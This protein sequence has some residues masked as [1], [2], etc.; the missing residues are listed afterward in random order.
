M[1]LSY[2]I[3]L[4]L[5]ILIGGLMS[6]SPAE[7]NKT[8]HE[9]MTDMAHSIAF[10]P[11]VNTYYSYNIWGTKQEHREFSVPRLPVA[12][13][14]ARGYSGT[15]SLLQTND[16]SISTTKNGHVNYY[17]KD[18]EEE[19]IRAANEIVSNPFPLTAKSLENGKAN[20]TIYCATCHGDKGD[21]GGYLVRDDGGKYPAQPANFLKDDF[22]ASSEGR[23]YHSIMYGKNMMGSYADKLNYEERWEVIHYIRSLQAVSKTLKY[24][25]EENTFSNSQAVAD[26]KKLYNSI[27][28]A[29]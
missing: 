12:G 3:S 16:K 21:G 6:C 15:D 20:Y 1:K 25:P 7:G 22:I 27:G 9:Y 26:F 10:E 19:R 8:G 24:S 18:T 17:Y 23:Y 13:T 11:N 29:R 5:M 2:Y 14:I 28:L 4:V